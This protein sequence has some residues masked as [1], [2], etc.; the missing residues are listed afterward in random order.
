MEPMEG[1][2]LE[3][4]RPSR[5]AV[6]ITNRKD[7]RVQTSIV[8]AVAGRDGQVWVWSRDGTAKGHNLA[9]DP[10][11]TL[12]VLDPAFHNWLHVEATMRIVHQPEA[13]PLLE[14]YYRLR[15]GGEH[16]SWDEYH[17]EMIRDKRMLFLGT[18]THVFQP[19][20]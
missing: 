14:D 9:R 10:R 17:Q 18:V 13:M 19:A 7:G 16:A 11:A 20:R 2:Q 6:M 3:F 12:C 8:T 4:V 1:D 15:H 5:P